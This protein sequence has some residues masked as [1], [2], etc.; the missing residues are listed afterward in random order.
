MD[1]LFRFLE[2]SPHRPGSEIRACPSQL[3]GTGNNKLSNKS[4][5]EKFNRIRVV[6]AIY[7]IISHKIRV[8][9]WPRFVRQLVL[10]GWVAA[11]N[12]VL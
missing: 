9:V 5:P 10:N 8:F 4:G 6:F 11:G 3:L 2:Y 7:W 1:L 12:K